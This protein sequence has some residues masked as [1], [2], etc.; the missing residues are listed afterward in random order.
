MPRHVTGQLIS[1]RVGE[2]PDERFGLPRVVIAGV[3]VI[4]AKLTAT[5]CALVALGVL[6]SG[7]PICDGLI[8]AVRMT[9]GALLSLRSSPPL[10]G[11][12]RA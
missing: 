3:I 4:S 7:V 8:R 9:T 10:C 6:A 1:A 12:P 11:K 5:V 2:G